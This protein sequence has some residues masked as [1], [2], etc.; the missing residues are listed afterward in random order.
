MP[1]LNDDLTYLQAAQDA[2][3]D[4]LLSNELFW[5][6]SGGHTGHL[7]RLSLGGILLAELRS[8]ARAKTVSQQQRFHTV[9]T[10]VEAARTRW[11][12][13]WERKAVREFESRL[14]QWANY[15][16]EYRENPA[17]QA[18]YYPY[19]ARLRVMLDLLRDECA[20][21]LP[22]HAEEMYRGLDVLLQAVFTPGEF[23]WDT[24]LR[25]GLPRQ[26]YWYLYGSLRT[27]R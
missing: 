20:G 6:V 27:R 17:A 5:P 21:A 1:T 25:A 14:R 3:E 23:I 16:N 15:L 4:F 9:Q 13:H 8:R 11:R 24:D 7:P 2:L 22:P 10:A 19:E 12:V 18:S 26:R